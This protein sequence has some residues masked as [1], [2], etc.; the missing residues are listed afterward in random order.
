MFRRPTGI[1]FPDRHVL[2][3]EIKTLHVPM[4]VLG[5]LNCI[6]TYWT[7]GAKWQNGQGEPG[8]DETGFQLHSYYLLPE[9]AITYTNN[10]LGYASYATSTYRV[11]E[12]YNELY[13]EFVNGF[14]G[15]TYYKQ[16]SEYRRQLGVMAREDL[17]RLVRR[18]AGREPARLAA[19][20]G[21]GQE[22]GPADHKQLYAVENSVNLTNTLKVYNRFAFGNDA[23]HPAQ[24]RLL[25][26]AVPS[27]RR[28]WRCTCSTDP[29]GSATARRRW[30]RAT[31]RAAATRPIS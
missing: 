30:T 16:R 9:R 21:Q 10:L 1:E 13:I 6:P 15:K 27:H 28:T 5:T 8:R 23:E 20:R 3:A 2:Q 22:R 26:V 19:G 11:R 18:G 14:T 17:Q 25:A 4:P 7:R 24:G 12:I 29:T 31:C